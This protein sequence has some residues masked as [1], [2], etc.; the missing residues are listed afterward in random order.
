MPSESRPIKLLALAS[1]MLAFVHASG[2]EA[3][4]GVIFSTDDPMVTGNLAA[5]STVTLR[6]ECNFGS[7]G[8]ISITEHFDNEKASTCA[9][10]P[11]PVGTPIVT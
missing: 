8:S 1:F 4:P 5:V 7:R 6:A 10:G 3:T 2:I 9:S 11:F